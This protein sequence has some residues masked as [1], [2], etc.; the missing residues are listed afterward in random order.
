MTLYDDQNRTL[1]DIDILLSDG[2]YAMAVEVKETL[3]READVE[4]HVKRMEL[5][6]KYPPAEVKGKRLLGAMAGGGVDHDVAKLA[7]SKG[8]F[9]LEL[10]GE[11]VRLVPPPSG[12]TPREWQ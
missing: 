10:A 7:Y 8:F 6:E 5:I 11:S 9:V 12:F 1:T 4:H 2:A 3:D